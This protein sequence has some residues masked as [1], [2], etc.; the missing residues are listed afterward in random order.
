MNDIVTRCAILHNMSVVERKSSYTGTR[1]TRI[2]NEGQGLIVGDDTPT[3]SPHPDIQGAY[4]FGRP[5]LTELREAA[6]TTL[7]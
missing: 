2:E 3:I 4:F 5:T 1:A 7:F 6:S